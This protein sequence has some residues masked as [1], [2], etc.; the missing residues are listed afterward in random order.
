M[1]SRWI[2]PTGSPLA[3]IGKPFVILIRS[4]LSCMIS[5]P[6]IGEKHNVAA[7][8]PDIVAKFNDY[9]ARRTY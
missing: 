5:M 2:A 8:H 6:I 1:G 4:H 9:F 7:D 3:V